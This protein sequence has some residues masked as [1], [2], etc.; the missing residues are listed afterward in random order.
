MNYMRKKCAL[1]YMVLCT[2]LALLLPGRVFAAEGT[3]YSCTI[4]RCYAHPVTGVIEDAGGEAAFTTGQGM[5]EG[6]IYDIGILE[7]TADGQYYL[8]IRKSLENYTKDLAFYVQNTGDS[9]WSST[10]VAVTS[11]GTDNNGDTADYRIQLP[12]ADAV[13]RGSMYVEPM[14]RDVVFYFYPSD[15]VEGNAYGMEQT[16][17]ASSANGEE[18]VTDEDTTADNE[19]ENSVQRPKPTPKVK[20][21]K[22]AGKGT[23]AVAKVPGAKKSE[24]PK[25]SITKEKRPDLTKSPGGITDV[26]EDG[27]TRGLTLSG[28]QEKE[29][30]AQQPAEAASPSPYGVIFITTVAVIVILF[31]AAGIVYYMRK[32]WKRWGDD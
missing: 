21:S 2:V 12:S 29:E 14:G 8:T 31:V 5:V 16:V 30:K 18:E 4:N 27:Q 13:V 3:V 15:Y 7:Q 6:T 28:S 10:D 23:A 11:T 25:S 1:L 22:T 26:G 32:N 24:G 17:V 9:D 20:K 19:T